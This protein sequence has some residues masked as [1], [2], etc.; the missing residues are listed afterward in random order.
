MG[1]SRRP[2]AATVGAT[3]A[4]LVAAAS[5]GCATLP[6]LHPAPPSGPAGMASNPPAGAPQ[7]AH[8]PHDFPRRPISLLVGSERGTSQDTAAR[9]LATPLERVVG[10]PVIVVNRPGGDG[11]D[12]WVQLKRSNADGYTLGLIAS[13]QIQV[14]ALDPRRGSPFSLGDFLT[15]ANQLYDPG[16][17]FVRYW[18]PFESI[19]DLIAAATTQP[20]RISVAIPAGSV[21]DA[22]AAA[23]LQRRAGRRLQVLSFS[24]PNGAL[25]AALSGQADASIGSVTGFGPSVRSGQGRV[26]AVLDVERSS[27]RPEVPTLRE[28]GIDVVSYRSLGYAYRSETAPDIVEYLSWALFAAMSDRDYQNRMRDAGLPA[29]FMG[30]EQ[31]RR[32]FAA[33][34]E[35]V[36]RLLPLLP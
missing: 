6:S 34:G 10:Q 32:L 5:L 35:K 27:D 7:E 2:R 25:M 29:R 19:H 4:A 12:A 3:L 18:S 31:Y 17:I 24:G 21:V 1:S 23:E 26:L 30:A 9:L 15:L 8:K 14:L 13:P 16:A 22:L 20:G 28:T 36:R 11:M 33:E